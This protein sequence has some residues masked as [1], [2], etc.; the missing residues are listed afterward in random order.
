ML[1]LI[2]GV[3]ESVSNLAKRLNFSF[4]Y[5]ES[6]DVALVFTSRHLAARPRGRH[7]PNAASQQLREITVVSGYLL[8]C[9]RNTLGM[10]SYCLSLLMRRIKNL[11]TYVCINT[12]I[13][14]PQAPS[15]SW[16]THNDVLEFKFKLFYSIKYSF[17][18][19]HQ[20]QLV[21]SE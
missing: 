17:L 20:I 2:A 8:S 11:K 16:F 14:E 9:L 5:V 4:I 7:G 13:L 21:C 3:D 6:T 15:K 19:I 10:L 12:L 1:L 18:E